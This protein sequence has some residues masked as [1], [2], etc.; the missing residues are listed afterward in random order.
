MNHIKIIKKS[1]QLSTVD[2]QSNLNYWK[3]ND[4]GELI[5]KGGIKISI[6]EHGN[7]TKYLQSNIPKAKMKTWIHQIL[8][9][10]ITKQW[11]KTH[12][13]QAEQ[14]IWFVENYGQRTT[15]GNLYSVKTVIEFKMYKGKPQ[16]EIKI[17]M[18]PGQ[19]TKTGSTKMVTSDRT[20]LVTV[21]KMLSMEEMMELAL[22]TDSYIK[23]SELTAFM[24]KKPM[25]DMMQLR[26]E[27]RKVVQFPASVDLSRMTNKEIAKL[28]N[29]LIK[30]V[31][32]RKQNKKENASM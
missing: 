10:Q 4:K 9:G 1:N 30:E 18:G 16:F 29:D 2:F 20:K 8:N 21:R 27:E 6:T 24:E 25:H 3:E 7:E 22:E 11:T 15:D 17:T 5:Y 23:N 14:D 32:K 12:N 19:K 31:N 26:S 13:H 28:Y